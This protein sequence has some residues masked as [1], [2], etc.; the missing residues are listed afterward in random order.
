MIYYD[1]L[2]L[3]KIVSYRDTLNFDWTE[4]C[5]YFIKFIIT[6]NIEVDKQHENTHILLCYY[7][8]QYI[9][10]SCVFIYSPTLLRDNFRAEMLYIFIF[11][12]VI[13]GN[14]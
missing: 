2:C 8:T 7:V 6:Y 9:I 13:V 5:I 12:D 4:E 3:H 14:Y 11:R 1:I 10:T